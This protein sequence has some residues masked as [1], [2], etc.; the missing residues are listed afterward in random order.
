MGSSEAGF[1][2]CAEFVL[3]DVYREQLKH[4][5][6]VTTHWP[7]LVFL[8]GSLAQLPGFPER[9]YTELRPLLPYGPIGDRLKVI[10]SDTPRLGAWYGARRLALD[11][12]VDIYVT[13]Q[14]YD[15]CGSDYLVEHPI[16]N[17]SW[18]SPL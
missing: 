17:R 7:G 3:R 18:R 5:D 9:I 12:R 16:G 14:L 4:P 15:E 2:E 1:G 6:T 13:R 8:T 11:N 10:V